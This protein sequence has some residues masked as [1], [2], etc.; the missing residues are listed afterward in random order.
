[1]KRNTYFVRQTRD[2]G[3]YVFP[4]FVL[5]IK[6]PTVLYLCAQNFVYYILWPINALA[7]F[8]PLAFGY[9][10]ANRVSVFVLWNKPNARS[11]L[12]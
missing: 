10:I 9:G 6:A 7:Y 12:A 3:C 5:A 1:M 11:A 2:I 4:L 8:C